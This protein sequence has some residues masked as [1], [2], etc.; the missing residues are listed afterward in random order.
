MK[1]F[2]GL[3]LDLSKRDVKLMMKEAGVYGDRIYLEGEQHLK[4]IF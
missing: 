1:T 2:R 4:Y 3:G